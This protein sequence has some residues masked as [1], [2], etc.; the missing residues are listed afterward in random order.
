MQSVNSNFSPLLAQPPPAHLLEINNILII[1]YNCIQYIN[2]YALLSHIPAQT[3]T[4]SEQNSLNTNN[5]KIQNIASP[6]PPVSYNNIISSSLVNNSSSPSHRTC[7][8]TPASPTS[9]RSCCSSPHSV[10]PLAPAPIAQYTISICPCCPSPYSHKHLSSVIVNVI[11]FHLHLN[12]T[13]YPLPSEHRPL[14]LLYLLFN[15]SLLLLPFPATLLIQY[16][17]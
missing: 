10:P 15:P 4:N 14:A 8:S 17:K 1:L 12:A 7:I 11:R 16:P 6:S 5:A 2:N 3:Q 13:T 9:K